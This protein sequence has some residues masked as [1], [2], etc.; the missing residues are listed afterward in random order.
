VVPQQ[1]EPEELPAQKSDPIKIEAQPVPFDIVEFTVGGVETL[2]RPKFVIPIS[3]NQAI[4]VPLSWKVEGG[5]DLKVELLPAPGT[6]PPE[7]TLPYELSPEAGTETITLQVTNEAGE[8]KSRSV[9]IETIQPPPPEPVEMTPLSPPGDTANGL[10]T[11]EP[12]PPPQDTSAAQT[13]TPPSPSP[14][15]SPSPGTS[16]SGTEPTPLPLPPGGSPPLP[17]GADSP[18]PAELPPKFR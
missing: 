2:T 1:G 5:R 9:T 15:P 18:P 3:G 6:V 7:G 4:P 8:Q 10:P 17:P 16:P 13:Q 11:F 12:P 14:S